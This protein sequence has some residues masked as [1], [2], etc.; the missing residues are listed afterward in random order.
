M[1]QLKVCGMKF[2][3]N[4]REVAKLQPDYLGFILYEGSARFFK[5]AIPDI[6][7]GIKTTGVFVNASLEKIL[8][9]VFEY[10]LKAVQLH[11]DENPAFCRELRQRLIR[12]TGRSHE[13]LKVFSVDDGFDLKELQ[14]YEGSVDHFLFDTRG[15]ERGGNGILFNWDLLLAYDS[16]TPFFL[17]GGI[18]LTETEEIKKFIDILQQKGKA[19]LLHG[20]DIN[21]RFESEPG[22]KRVEDIKAFKEELSEKLRS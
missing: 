22:R 16:P 19:R 15:K 12:D 11:G 20:I 3:D 21:S 18:G 5:T 6:G 9:K 1:I 2:P 7:A 17:S 4:I 10:D 8:E 14:P 13:I